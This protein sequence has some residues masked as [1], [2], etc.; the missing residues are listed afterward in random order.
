M[1][2]ARQIL[3]ML[4]F[5]EPP[6]P[7]QPPAGDLVASV[8]VGGAGQL[9]A[10]FREESY[11]PGKRGGADLY[12]PRLPRRAS[13]Q[14]RGQPM[15][16]EGGPMEV[17]S[18]APGE[19]EELSVDASLA[20]QAIMDMLAESDPQALQRLSGVA[21]EVVRRAFE[22]MAEAAAVEKAMRATRRPV[23]APVRRPT[24][25]GAATVPLLPPR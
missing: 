12:V 18:F 10:T 24:V 1:A 16:I 5:G 2:D 23:P 25:A 3:R 21:P 8:T 13:L 20:R 4:L 7:R 9:P 14:T 11:W 15:E 19:T 22:L 17:R 6:P